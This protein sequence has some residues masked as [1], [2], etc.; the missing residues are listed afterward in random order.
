MKRV[1]LLISGI[2]SIAV[3]ACNPTEEKKIGEVNMIEVTEDNPD[4]EHYQ[5]DA[6]DYTEEDTV[7]VDT[8]TVNNAVADN[9][10]KEPE[11][12]ENEDGSVKEISDE[13]LNKKEV[14]SKDAVT[15]KIHVKKF[16]I[17]A[18]SFKLINN[19]TDLRKFFR[20]KGYP[21]MILYPYHGYNRVAT[22]SYMTRAAA[23]KDIKQFRRINLMYKDERIEYWL[24][25]R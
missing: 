1:Y 13:E 2:I 24:L 5:E 19:A 12:V 23:E 21:A 6:E 20:G 7:L 8:V 14:K 25:W 15:K 16:Y 9:T 18:G 3:I 22:G 11:M 4:Y 10:G 17:I